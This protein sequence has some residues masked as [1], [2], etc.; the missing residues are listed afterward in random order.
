VKNVPSSTRFDPSR[1]LRRKLKKEIGFRQLKR[2]IRMA[3][4]AAKRA[5][6]TDE[7]TKDQTTGASSG[8]F[9]DVSGTPGAADHSS[10]KVPAPGD[11]AHVEQ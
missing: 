3:K 7:L 2:R 10:T 5:Q 6:T 11:E 9:G 1:A 4:E 8:T